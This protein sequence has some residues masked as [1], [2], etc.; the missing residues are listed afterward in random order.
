MLSGSSTKPLTKSAAL[1]MVAVFLSVLLLG[2][3]KVGEAT[4]GFVHL[5]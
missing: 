4:E 1:A 2:K 3:A 5:N